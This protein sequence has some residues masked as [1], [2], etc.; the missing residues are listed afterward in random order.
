M[1]LT[2]FAMECRDK[3]ESVLFL[4][5]L[6]YWSVN[7]WTLQ[8]VFGVLLPKLMNFN[9]S[10]LP[11]F[12]F[13][14]LITLYLQFKLLPHQVLLR[15]FATS[16]LWRLH[17]FHHHEWFLRAHQ[18][19]RS[20]FVLLQSRIFLSICRLCRHVPWFWQ[21]E[22][23]DI[24]C[25]CGFCYLPPITMSIVFVRSLLCLVLFQHHS[26]KNALSWRIVFQSFNPAWIVSFSSYDN[27]NSPANWLVNNIRQVCWNNQVLVKFAHVLILLQIL[28]VFQIHL[29]LIIRTCIC[30]EPIVNLTGL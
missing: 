10:Y 13:C 8:P 12:C 26:R 2:V 7:Y 18:V 22:W 20:N 27:W 1:L 11:H 28:F 15:A 3:Q 16:C 9:D 29:T 4:H 23:V 25:C 6:K 19:F 24:N 5:I 30:C 21:V 17:S 14:S